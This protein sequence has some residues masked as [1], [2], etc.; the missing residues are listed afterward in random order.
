MPTPKQQV[1]ASLE[2]LPDTATFDD[3]LYRVYVI[4]GINAG[5]ADARAGR[6][7]SHEDVKR[8]IFNWLHDDRQKPD[9]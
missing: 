1:I 7:V 6:V 8:E 5:M 4:H 3:L 2:Q 9:A